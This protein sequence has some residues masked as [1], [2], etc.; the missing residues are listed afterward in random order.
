MNNVELK[1]KVQ[2]AASSILKDRIYI[3][4]VDLLMEIDI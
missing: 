3:S 1:H 2:S 4:P